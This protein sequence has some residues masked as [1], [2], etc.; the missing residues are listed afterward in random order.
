MGN[1]T[2]NFTFSELVTT[3]H[4]DLLNEN[5]AEASHP[6]VQHNLELL[7]SLILQ[8]IRDDFEKPLVITS[9]FRCRKL[10]NLV[11]G[12]QKSYHLLGKACDFYIKGEDLK[13]AYSKIRLLE[14][15]YG[16]IIL[17]PTWIHIQ[18]AEVS[19]LTRSCL[20]AQYDKKGILQY[21]KYDDKI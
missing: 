11:K 2:K 8:P 4:K 10:N 7:A 21:Y 16:T 17:E 6:A 9:G 1:L 13:I 14:I 12:E 3:S 5:F 20:V 18:L 19:Q 15:P